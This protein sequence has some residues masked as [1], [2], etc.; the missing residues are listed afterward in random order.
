MAPQKVFSQQRGLRR[1]TLYP[2]SLIAII[3]EALSRMLSKAEDCNLISGSKASPDAPSVSHLQYA[4]EP[5]LFC[6]AEDDQVK[7]MAAILRCFEAV[8]GLRI[9]FSKSAILGVSV[10]E[11]SPRRLVDTLGC[12]VD[13]FPSTYLGL[14]LCLGRVLKYVWNPVVERMEKKLSS[15]KARHLS[16]EAELP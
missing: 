12:K 8:L 7:N 1:G 9:N 4:D 14:P 16:W 5:F 11:I 10:D 3:G 15:W 2:C 13:C 6:D